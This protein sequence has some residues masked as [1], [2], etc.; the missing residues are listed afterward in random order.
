MPRVDHELVGPLGAVEVALILPK[1][2]E[3][4]R[5]LRCQIGVPGVDRQLQ[6]PLRSGETTPSI[7]AYRHHRTPTYRR[8]RCAPFFT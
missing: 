1:Y 8:D 5:R 3:I 4:E 7:L 2:P 6:D